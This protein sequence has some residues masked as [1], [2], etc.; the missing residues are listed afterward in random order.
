MKIGVI[1]DS[2]DN[3]PNIET[4]IKYFKERGITTVIHCGD[5][6]APSVMKFIAEQF[7]DTMHLVY[8]NVDGDQKKMEEL[9]KNLSTLTIHGEVGRIEIDNKKI[10]FVHYPWEAEKL[11]ESGQYDVIFYG[12]DHKA[13]TKKIGDT[14]LFNPGTLAG[15]FAKPTFAVYDTINNTAELILVETLI[16]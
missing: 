2:H 15:L 13:W 1:S 16:S 5:V 12:H 11:A 3:V 6:C 9:A 7:G 14:L 8:G 4:A 10:G